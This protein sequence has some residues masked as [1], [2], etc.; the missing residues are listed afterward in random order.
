MAWKKSSL[1]L[2]SVELTG[3]GCVQELTS[4]SPF[5]GTQARKKSILEQKNTKIWTENIPSSLYC[6]TDNTTGKRS[7]SA[8]LFDWLVAPG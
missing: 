3:R 5:S 7:N 4:S 1:I 8:V 6:V 2:S